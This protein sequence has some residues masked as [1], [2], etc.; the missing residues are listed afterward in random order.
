[1]VLGEH[2]LHP[3]AAYGGPVWQVAAVTR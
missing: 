2:G 3:I 1:V